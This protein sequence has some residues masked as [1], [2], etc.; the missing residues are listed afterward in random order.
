M[1][2]RESSVRR[3]ATGDLP[4]CPHCHIQLLHP[5]TIRPGCLRGLPQ[6][7]APPRFSVTNTAPVTIRSSV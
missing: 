4:C 5:V 3:V 6:P 7:A 2:R 1:S